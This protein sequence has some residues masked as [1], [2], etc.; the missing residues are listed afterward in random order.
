MVAQCVLTFSSSF[1]S[2]QRTCTAKGTPTPAPPNSPSAKQRTMARDICET[3][4]KSDATGRRSLGPSG[5]PKEG[6]KGTENVGRKGGRSVSQCR[7][8]WRRKSTGRVEKR[9][10]RSGKIYL[11]EG[12]NKGRRKKSCV[13]LVDSN[14][15]DAV[16]KDSVKQHF[17]PNAAK[18]TISRKWSYLRWTK[19]T[20]SSI[21]A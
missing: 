4:R 8:E 1:F 15:R 12:E 20:I 3:G 19:P 21:A 11:G 2:C 10:L 18:N 16:T 5:S 14:G 7:N 6:K 9:N 13:I 17:P